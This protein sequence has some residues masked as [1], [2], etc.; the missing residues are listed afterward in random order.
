MPGIRVPT[1]DAAL[2]RARS[3]DAM[4]SFRRKVLTAL[5][6]THDGAALLSSVAGDEF[7]V[8]AADCA[9]AAMVFK[10]AAGARRLMNN[11]SATSDA[12]RLPA[13]A[14]QAAA[15]NHVAS[16]ADLNKRNQAYWAD[17]RA[18]LAGSGTTTH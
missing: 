9:S 10:A 3:V 4:C 1:F 17:Q 5:G 11:R 18:K 7:D 12:N 13:S 2:P 15:T 16:L 14:I 6:T 8:E